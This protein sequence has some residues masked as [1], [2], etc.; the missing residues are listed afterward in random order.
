MRFLALIVLVIFSRAAQA[1]ILTDDFTRGVQ[2]PDGWTAPQNMGS[3]SKTDG[4]G[5]KGVINVE[6]SGENS[7]AWTHP[8]SNLQPGSLLKLSFLSRISPGSS[9]ST[10]V[11]GLK[12]INRDFT[13]S[14]TWQPIQYV[15]TT[16]PQASEDILRLGQWML[17]GTL[18]IAQVRLLAVSPIYSRVDNVELGEG[19]RAE[20]GRYEF[21]APLNGEGSN[22]ARVLHGFSATFNSNRW[23]FAQGR[24]VVYRF[25]LP[26]TRLTDGQV[27]MDVNY[28][29]DGDLIVQ[30][31][32]DGSHWQE[33]GRANHTGGFTYNLPADM[34]SAGTVYIRLLGG[35]NNT[36]MQ[37]DQFRFTAGLEGQ[38]KS[39]SI[40]GLTRYLETNPVV[41]GKVIVADAG[42][43]GM[44]NSLDTALLK[45]RLNTGLAPCKGIAKMTITPQNGKPVSFSA[46]A[47]LNAAND[48]TVRLPYRIP[49]TGAL[50]IQFTVQPVGKTPWRADTN[51]T[52]SSYFSSNYG[53]RLPVASGPDLWWCEGTYKVAPMRAL[54]TARTA[55]MQ[56]T[57]AGRERQARQLV[58]S[59]KQ[60]VGPIR[61]SVS[62]L[63]NNR[64]S[65]IPSSAIEIRRVETVPVRIPTDAIGMAADWPDPLPLLEGEWQPQPGRNQALWITITVPAGTAAGDYTGSIT[66]KNAKWTRTIPLSLHVWAFQLPEYTA[67]RSGFGISPDAIRRYHHIKSP[68]SMDKQ[69][70]LYMRNFAQH[71]LCPYNPMSLTSIDYKLSADNQSYKF[72]F[73]GF[74]R[75]VTRYLD[76]MGFNSFVINMPGMG[77]G[78]Y[79]KYDLGS[80]NG[81]DYGTPEYDRLMTDYGKQLTDHLKSKGWLNK[82]YTYWYDEPETADYPFVTDRMELIKRYAPGLKRMLTEEF[83]KPLLGK[84]DLWCPVLSNYSATVAPQRQKLGEEVWWYICCVP[85]EPYIGEFIDHPAIESRM[86]LWQTWKFGVQGVLIWETAWWT[87]DAQF[88]TPQDPW[89]DPMSYTSEGTGTWG[90]GDG[91]Y[92][93]PPKLKPASTDEVLCEPIPSMRWELLT[94]G[95]QDWEYLSLLKQ[96]VESARNNGKSES[97]LAKARDLLTVPDSICKDLTHYT[98]DPQLLLRRRDAIAREIERLSL[99]KSPTK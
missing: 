55:S 38:L 71:R 83:Q 59:T 56:F 80:L 62:G 68:E 92:F 53:Y 27:T 45:I 57:A 54:P 49:A 4:P 28:R 25:S 18:Q 96:K 16:S 3:W 86:W 32:V 89:Q 6:G 12:E 70:N 50:G 33:I 77:G 19:E 90:N 51:V 85:K 20:R 76:G 7:G 14:E 74:D 31:G 63:V 95:I 58:L 41:W 87:S 88:K 84:I 69:W 48:I 72:D 47:I 34:A 73:T 99:Y 91:R 21:N 30:S 22:S 93:Y 78:R 81:H 60:A 15:F 10:V 17:K 5:N 66:L 40:I 52:V 61:V 94:E 1:Q 42:S 35:G 65:R 79:P 39:S 37:V 75:E 29:I 46:D 44:N 64:S 97:S 9:S 26:D 24:D 2:Q 11:A 8:I 13:A 23:C 36:N 67:L 98:T 82:A 43:F